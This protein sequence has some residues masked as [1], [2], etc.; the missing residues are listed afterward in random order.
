MAA[1]VYYLYIPYRIVYDG[2]INFI[3]WH[4][5]EME[6]SLLN[7]LLIFA[8]K[9]IYRAAAQTGEVGTYISLDFIYLVLI[10]VFDVVRPFSGSRECG[11]WK[12][13]L[14][15]AHTFLLI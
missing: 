15:D 5:H 9:S 4:L 13:N 2:A 12:L 1:E 8:Y 7:S 3:L 10:A 14:I 6:N 11:S